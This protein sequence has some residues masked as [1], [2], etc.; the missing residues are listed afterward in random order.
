MTKEEYIIAA[1]NEKMPSINVGNYHKFA[2]IWVVVTRGRVFCRQATKNKKGW[3]AALL[4][5]SDG[6]LKFENDTFKVIGKP[7]T[8]IDD[9]TDDINKA[10][11]KKYGRAFSWLAIVAWFMTRKKY[12]H[13]TMELIYNEN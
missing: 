6:A 7:P 5:N 2:D 3:Y 4:E 9:L 12:W 1:E 13:K 11:L 8:D 10:Y